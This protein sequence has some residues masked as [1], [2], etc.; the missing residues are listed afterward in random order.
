MVVPC[1]LEFL[2]LNIVTNETKFVYFNYAFVVCS[3]MMI[4]VLKIQVSITST[5]EECFATGT[6]RIIF[7]FYLYLNVS[8]ELI[9]MVAFSSFFFCL[10]L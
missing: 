4:N 5:R 7:R 1:I 8:L 3:P 2:K 10:L 9:P 6:R